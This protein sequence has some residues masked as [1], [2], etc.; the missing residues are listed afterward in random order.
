[1]PML[2]QGTSPQM[3][4]HPASCTY[5]V[6]ARFLGSLADKMVA[7]GLRELKKQSKLRIV[8]G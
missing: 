1:M 3:L 2:D 8:A 4:L 7:R 6:C 5:A